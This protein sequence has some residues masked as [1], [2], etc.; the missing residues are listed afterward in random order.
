MRDST[1][2]SLGPTVGLAVAL[3]ILGA[4]AVVSYFSI[5]RFADGAK[6]VQL[7]H[8]AI[9]DM[10]DVLS[11]LSESEA[12]HHAF[13]VT[14]ESAHLQGY[15]TA[16]ASLADAL[17]ALKQKTG[18]DP[19]QRKRVQVLEESIAQH[20]K[21]LQEA[22]ERDQV[23]TDLKARS[24]IAMRSIRD[25][26]E[27]MQADEHHLLNARAAQFDR[28][29]TTVGATIVAGSALAL[30][31]LL[32][33]FW[34][35]KRE[36]ADR[37]NAERRARQLA[38]ETEDLYNNAPCGY[39]SLDG[40][41]VVVRMND[42]ELRWLGYTHEEV[43]G[44]MNFAALL[45]PESRKR[46]LRHFHSFKERGS[47]R[48]T[49]LGMLRKDGT[50]LHVSIT[51]TVVRDDAGAYRMSRSTVFDMT[52][53]REAQL[54]LNQTNTF[55]DSL[56]EHIPDMMFVKEAEHLRFVRFNRAGEELLGYPRAELLGKSDHDFFPPEEAEFFVRKDREVLAGE[57]VVDI[58]EERIHTRYLGERVLHTKKIPILDADGKPLYL[59]GISEDVTERRRTERQISDL[60]RALAARAGEL[61]VTN[62]ELESFSYSVSHDLR[63]PLRAIDGFSKML[64]EDYDDKLD[65]E[66]KRLLRVVRE[67]SRRMARLIDDLLAFSRL[68]RQHMNLVPVDMHALAYEALEEAITSAGG[69]SVAVVAE[70]LP[71]ARGDRALLRQVW[72]NLLSNAVKYSSIREQPR[73][74]LS[75]ARNGSE[76]V[77]RVKDN[78]VGFDMKYYDKLF[79]VFQRL[80]GNDEF[81][82]IGV[83]LA[84]VQRVVTRHGGRA[85]AESQLGEGATFFFSLPI[86]AET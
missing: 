11:L 41:G 34:A 85:W 4:I 70:T 36:I 86:G 47:L 64:E 37:V 12:E 16:L 19:K 23:D 60:N 72:V 35:L 1:R 45:S 9:E 61:E 74:E 15:R 24:H 2:A 39:H 46:F 29:K 21:L 84:I 75:A 54:R 69:R 31:F 73:V 7:S 66:G 40:D 68:G 38:A 5:Y 6:W 3:L 80:H 49:E 51:A 57:R 53:R 25:Q 58:E 76:T 62:K 79:G 52:D 32:I 30:A 8:L 59:L 42:T 77:Y 22:I 44:K 14:H 65:P 55:L 63:A 50:T 10:D 33:A 20:Q 71:A 56:V 83:G 26:V 17:R 81:P 43:V 67:N 27:V 48:D 18:T 13:L 78:G 82:G 28:E